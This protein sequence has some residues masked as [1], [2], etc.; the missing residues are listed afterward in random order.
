[1]IRRS[2]AD[3]NVSPDRF[4][5]DALKITGTAFYILAA[6]LFITSGINIYELHRPETTL[7][8]AVISA[9]SIMTMWALV[10][11]KKKVGLQLNSQ[12]ILADADCTKICVYMSF[13]LLFSSA[14][15]E[16]TGIGHLDAIGALL[17]AGLSFKEGRE[18]FEKARGNAV[19]VCRDGCRR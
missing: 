16:F 10:R 2:K 18:S 9:I 6:G 14:G 7:W 13:V 5:R 19:C 12:A 8:G 15:Y 3:L 11:S 1:M 17:I 4:E